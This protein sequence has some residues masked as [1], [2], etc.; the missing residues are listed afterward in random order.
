MKKI[1]PACCAVSQALALILTAASF[2]SEALAQA[3]VHTVSSDDTSKAME[4]PA[5]AN[6]TAAAEQPMEEGTA[7]PL[8]VGDATQNLLAWQRSGEIASSTPR[9]IA[10][11]VAARSYERYLKSFE[12]P[13]PERLTS[14][15][16][17]TS[18]STGNQ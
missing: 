14:S 15:V 13:I 6:T 18:S 17:K 12:H 16:K 7:T 5:D 8:Q 11:A 3:A 4:A 9:P 1:T 10:G 2:T